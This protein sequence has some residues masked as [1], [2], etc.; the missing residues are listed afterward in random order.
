MMEERPIDSR[1]HNSDTNAPFE[2]CLVCQ[3]ALA[4]S[5]DDYFIERIFRRVEAMDVVEP[6]FE[7]GICASCAENMRKSLSEESRNKIEA[8]FSE[9]IRDRGVP[10]ESERLTTCLLTGKR[11]EDSSEFSYHAHCRNDKMIHSIFPY[12]ISDEAMDEVSELLSNDTLDQLDDFKGKY[13]TGPPELA[14]ILSPK[15]FVPL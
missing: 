8:L 10:S 11:I 15:K 13:F 5:G 3:N 2:R 7:Y 9:R 4:D 14:D 6:I 12:A 1:F